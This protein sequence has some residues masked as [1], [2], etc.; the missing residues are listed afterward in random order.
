MTMV[1]SLRC[2]RFLALE[3]VI[4]SDQE[5]REPS[6]MFGRC[7]MMSHGSADFGGLSLI[8]MCKSLGV[9]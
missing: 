9:A 8:Q 6:I 2:L 1:F 7:G 3:K 4:R 5:I